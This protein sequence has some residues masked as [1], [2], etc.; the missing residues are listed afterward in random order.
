MNA[1]R[2][3]DGL[4]S[5]ASTTAL[6]GH[7]QDQVEPIHIQQ[8]VRNF[9]SLRRASF[10]RSYNTIETLVDANILLN[11]DDR[12]ETASIFTIKNLHDKI[13]DYVIEQFCHH[14]VESKTTKA[15]KWILE[16][17]QLYLDS[18]V[19]PFSIN[20][21]GLWL[22]EF[23]VI[24]RLENS[25]R[26]WNVAKK[27]NQVFIDCAK[28]L[29]EQ[30]KLPNFSMKDLRSIQDTQSK[31]GAE[32]EDWVVEYEK[33]R[34]E[35]HILKSQIRRVSED[36]SSAGYDVVSFSESRSL[37]HDLFIEVKSYAENE[38]FFW[39]INEIEKAR[40]IGENYSLYLVDRNRM[41]NTNYH[42]IIISGPYVALMET[43]DSGWEKNVS[44]YEFVRR[45]TT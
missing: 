36:H 20:G 16:L 44:S 6:V 24:D 2:Q 23:G 40:I 28:Q 32:A 29:N 22:R 39:S 10:T 35:G 26:Y 8:L 34:H 27:H 30:L 19:V 15:I 1:E 25:S 43:P 3:T 38:R 12:I 21:I 31:R 45:A 33:K 7:V 17:E 9:T 42:P 41:N 4:L 13:T 11:N 18:F 14:I 37:S 5:A